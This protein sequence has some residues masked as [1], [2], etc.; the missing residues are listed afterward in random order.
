MGLGFFSFF[1]A[2]QDFLVSSFLVINVF[3]CTFFRSQ[4]YRGPS[5]FCL[6]SFKG[7]RFKVLWLFGS[8]FLWSW[9]FRPWVFKGLRSF[10]SGFLG[11][12]IFQSSVPKVLRSWVRLFGIS[13]FFSLCSLVS[14]AF[15]PLG[16]SGF[17]VFWVRLFGSQ[18]FSIL[19]FL[20]LALCILGLLDQRQLGLQI[21]GCQVLL[22]ADFQVLGFLNPFWVWDFWSL[23]FFQVLSLGFCS[24]LW[25]FV[26]II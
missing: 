8:G 16:I 13:V 5:S 7:F 9:A 24:L 17:K 25:V 23:L 14:Q 10:G 15:Q 4:I 11:C 22:V 19:R 26:I 12:R 2:Y 20:F 18:V 1:F 3:S 6:S 21:E